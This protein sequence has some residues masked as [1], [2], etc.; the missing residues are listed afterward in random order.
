MNKN[1][2]IGRYHPTEFQYKGGADEMYIT[3]DL[4]QRTRGN[5]S[6][7][8]PKVRRV[9]IAGDVKDWK[10]GHIKKR[11]G[12]VV[13]GV[14]IEYEQSRK[15]YHRKGYTASRGDTTY[16]VLP[17]SVK[18]SSQMFRKVVEIPEEARNIHFYTDAARLPEEYQGALQ[19]VR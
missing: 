9:Y 2:M 8:Y 17:A 10:L 18:R 14:V 12:R 15:S 4:K 13:Y 3:Y 5:R 16:Q 11:S 6:A 7:L 1:T 19:D